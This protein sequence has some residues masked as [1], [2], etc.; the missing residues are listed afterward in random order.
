M[1]ELLGRKVTVSIGGTSIATGR[2]KT[3]TIGNT[4]VDV[5]SDTDDG[6]KRVLAEMGE[7]NW[8]FNM[9]GMFDEAEDSLYTLALNKTDV[10]A[11]VILTF[12]SFTLT[13]TGFM[14]NFNSGLPYSDAITFTADFV[15]A[16]EL[17]KAPVI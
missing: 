14:T 2:T 1:P 8:A 9:E 5:T 6:I 13:G 4:E 7:K 16:D 11:E 12:P 3:I 17:V 15:G 10:T